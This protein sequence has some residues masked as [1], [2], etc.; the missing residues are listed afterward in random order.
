MNDLR[1]EGFQSHSN[2]VLEEQSGHCSDCRILGREL[3]E[4]IGQVGV[5]VGYQVEGI[6]SL[7]EWES[8][9]A[10]E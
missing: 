2:I 8:D 6:E 10:T 9:R 7:F 5:V 1:R 4:D 3:S